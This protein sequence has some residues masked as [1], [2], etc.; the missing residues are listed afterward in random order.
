M[1]VDIPLDSSIERVNDYAIRT[2]DNFSFRD[3]T[4]VLHRGGLSPVY[5]TEPAPGWIDAYGRRITIN[6]YEVSIDGKNVYTAA[7]GISS[8]T[9]GVFAWNPTTSLFEETQ[10]EI[11]VHGAPQE[12]ISNGQWR[13]WIINK[14]ADFFYAGGWLYE[15]EQG[16]LTN[17]R[18]DGTT[19]QNISID[20]ASVQDGLFFVT[21]WY[22]DTF[23]VGGLCTLYNWDG[24]IN[25]QSVA[26]NGARVYSTSKGPGHCLT[27][28]LSATTMTVFKE[29]E[30]FPANF[31]IINRVPRLP[32]DGITNYVSITGDPNDIRNYTSNA[33]I[34][35]NYVTDWGLVVYQGFEAGAIWNWQ[36]TGPLTTFTIIH[37]SAKQHLYEDELGNRYLVNVGNTV[38]LTIQKA[39]E[40]VWL[41]ND[42]S[43]I[44][45]TESE[46]VLNNPLHLNMCFCHPRIEQSAVG[47]TLEDSI[48]Y[49]ASNNANYELTNVR[50][51]GSVM[52]MIIWN[53]N[54]NP[55][56]NIP[57]NLLIYDGDYYLG[58][59]NTGSAFY[60]FSIENE[61]KFQRQLLQKVLYPNPGNN[62]VLPVPP[63]VNRTRTRTPAMMF[64]WGDK[65]TS[66]GLT[67]D[68]RT[69]LAYYI[70]SN[71]YGGE[72]FFY[73]L[74]NY[75]MFDGENIYTAG[76]TPGETEWNGSLTAIAEGLVYMA[77]DSHQALFNSPLDGWLYTFRGDLQVR[78]TWNL[79][80]ITIKDAVYSPGLDSY[81]FLSD[82]E[83]IILN[84]GSMYSIKGNYSAVDT[85]L[86]GIVL[87]GDNGSFIIGP[88][89]SSIALPQKLTTSYVQIKEGFIS[90]FKDIFIRF[91]KIDE[92]GPPRPVN[93]NLTTTTMLTADKEIVK[94]YTRKLLFNEGRG[95]EVFKVPI[96][97]M[98]RAIAIDLEIDGAAQIQGIAIDGDPMGITPVR[99]GVQHANNYK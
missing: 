7:G 38:P 62:V 91:Q 69:M 68:N 90:S 33:A 42:G 2:V 74:R 22:N 72:T 9:K 46:T 70:F 79:S 84:K 86:K 47:G 97:T 66:V 37:T 59:L 93:I 65:I 43:S 24:T 57:A 20:Y 1:L 27:F 80:N 51:V 82:E 96:A 30:T 63:N 75:Y 76:S 39:S 67:D 77:S 23:N 6:D 16:S 99:S 49:A 21:W 31:V 19:W 61:I 8:P 17:R 3:N 55:L 28:T 56:I 54:G 88:Q 15:I 32:F 81:A 95:F 64:T 73:F 94:K 83:V 52:P 85:T 34:K 5:S 18:S 12:I 92:G 87:Y 14:R 44:V 13:G 78:P 53:R 4:S 58:F 35:F 48:Y 89:H 25:K 29:F 98:G 40:Y 71:F 60:T 50:S 26:P 45:S 11:P 10:S 36:P 41:L